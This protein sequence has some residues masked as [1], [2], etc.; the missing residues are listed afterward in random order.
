MVNSADGPFINK[1]EEGMATSPG[2]ENPY[3]GNQN[4]YFMTG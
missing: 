2:A 4:R 3:F 1:A